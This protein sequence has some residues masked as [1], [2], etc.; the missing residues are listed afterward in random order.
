MIKFDNSYLKL[1]ERFY[2]KVKVD[3]HEN[4]SIV[5]L[6]QK[7]TKELFGNSTENMST[8]DLVRILSAQTRTDSS[9][10]IALAYAGHQFGHFNPS[11]GDGRAMLLGEVVTPQNKRFDVHLK[12]TGATPFSRRGDGKSALGPVLREYILCEAMHRLHVPTTRALAVF[13]TGEKVLREE[14]LKGGVFTRV[15]KS[16]I[17][18]GTFEYFYYNRDIE[19]LKML[20]DYSIDRHYPQIAHHQNKYIEF[21]KLVLLNQATM[22]SKWMSLGFIHGVMNT[23][24]MTITGETIDYGPCAFIDKFSFNKTFSSIDRFKRYS[25]Q[26]QVSVGKWNF[27][28]LVNSLMPIIDEDF[29]KAQEKVSHVLSTVDKVYEQAYLREMGK[30]FGITNAN[31]EHLAIIQL[32][33]KYI[34]THQMDFTVAFRKLTDYQE[35]FEDA[36]FYQ[37]WEGLDIDINLMEQS[38]PYIIPRNHQLEFSIDEA[39]KG[40]LKPFYDLNDAL[41]NPFKPNPRYEKVPLAHEVVEY[42]FCGT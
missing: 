8:D 7:L 21:L 2:R 33:L 30:K 9:A 39:Y 19:G 16:H 34:E 40:N 18:I 14:V 15:A 22:V 26:N 20:A 24:N 41:S 38:N 28:V 37:L 3:E 12:G 42:T 31:K 4:L 13:S 36:D 10:N 32:F 29:S 5:K 25:Y 6:N 27:S 35:Q 11:L 23:D 1:P 17:R